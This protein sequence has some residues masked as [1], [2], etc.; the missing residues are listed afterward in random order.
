MTAATHVSA[1]RTEH[2]LF[3]VSMAGVMMA[4]ALAGFAASYLVP[5]ATGSFV[6]PSVLHLH[7]LIAFAWTALFLS[8]T[9]LVS[10]G[11]TGRHQAMGLFG[12][13]L[14]TAMVFSGLMVGAKTLS[15]GIASG[16][17]DAARSFTIFPVTIILLFAGF[18]AAAIANISRP[19]IH[20]RLML[21]ASIVT[22]PPALG[23]TLGHIFRDEALP[24]QIIGGAPPSLELG[25][26]ASLAADGFLVVAIVYDWLTRG[27]PHRVYVYGLAIMLLV[28]GLRIPLSQTPFWRGVTDVLLSL[29]R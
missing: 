13:A 1:A 6:G 7:A 10:G 16:H 4:T 22:M 8:Q 19:E 29:G 2:R 17:E 11:H 18:V 20:K 15:E 26:V 21:I 14:A 23:R 3:Y 24:R 5:V 27:R 9:M 28:Q 25:T 12:I